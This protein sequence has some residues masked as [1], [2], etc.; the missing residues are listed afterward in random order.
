M[1]HTTSSIPE[2]GKP[3]LTAVGH[4]LRPLI[5]LLL[6]RGITCTVFCDMVRATYIKVAESEF[7]LDDKPQTDSRISLLTGIHRREVNRVR[8]EKE[9]RITLSRHA[10][11]SAQLLAIWSGDQEYVD[12]Q[13][14]PI[15][16]PR[17]AS[18]GSEKSFESLVQSISKDFRARVVLDEWLRQGVV[19][20]DEDD[21]VHLSPEAF[22][23]PGDM[24]EKIY[25]F[26]KNIHDHMAATVHNLSGNA[27]PYLERCV[28]YDRLSAESVRELSDY[29]RS[30]GM[31][32]LQAVNRRAA[33]LQKADQGRADTAYRIN[34]GI[35]N[36]SAMEASDDEVSTK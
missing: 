15:P 34:F 11:L 3:L 35:Y 14:N 23:Q 33:A 4:I 12:D 5:R 10:S 32:A 9:D 19:R 7:K 20:M 29:A 18:K 36:F 26:G 21:N 2:S 1:E 30:T 16:L 24:G 17:L 13:G 8:N 25:Y 31:R 6:A 28:F 22:L 27:P